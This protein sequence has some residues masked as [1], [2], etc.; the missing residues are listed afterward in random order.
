MAFGRK[1]PQQSAPQSSGGSKESTRTTSYPQDQTG[2]ADV[3]GALRTTSYKSSI[4]WNTRGYE[5]IN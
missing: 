1:R 3:V 2:K 4:Q 5:T